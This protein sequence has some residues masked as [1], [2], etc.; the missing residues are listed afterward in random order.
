MRKDPIMTRM[1]V[2]YELRQEHFLLRRIPVIIRLDGNAFHTLTKKFDKPFDKDFQMAMKQTAI[3]LCEKIQGAKCAY[4]QSDEIS[5]LLT[6]F[7]RFVTEPWF[8]YEQSKVE[9]ISA[10]MASVYF[11]LSFAYGV[12]DSKARN[13]P[14]EE[15]CNYFHARQLDWIR[16]SILMYTSSVYSHKEMQNKNQKDMHEMLHAK[17]MN[18]AKLPLSW[19]NGIFIRKADGEWRESCPIFKSNRDLIE[20]L[21]IAQE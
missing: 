10:G 14:K 15:V 2:N 16:N 20:N 17:N 3:H 4:V 13:Y 18:W 5:V 21:L 8:N 19:K 1:K 12:F 11:A 7:D 9:S 6:D